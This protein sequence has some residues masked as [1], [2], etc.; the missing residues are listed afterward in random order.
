[1]RRN[2]TF[3][4]FLILF[5]M[6][7]I[8]VAQERNCSTMENLEYR[9]QQ[10]PGLVQRMAQLETYTQTKA[11]ELLQSKIVGDIITI[12]VV[13]HI[14]YR[15]SQENISDAQI[16]S[17]IDVLNEDF[18]RLNS[19]ADN[20]WSQAA[21]MQIEFCLA[22]VDPNGNATTGITRKSSTR[23][24]WGTN[25]A[26]KSVSQGGVAAW[27]TSEY[28]N[29]WV[30]N[31]GG[32]ILGYAQF[33]GGAASTDGVVMSPQYFGSSDKGTGFYLSAPFDKGR[34][35]THEVGH[36]LNLRHIWGDGGCG[37][38]D[39][40]SDT[41]TSD[42]S[43]GGC[44]IGH[45]SCGTVDM[46]QNYMDYSDDACMNLFTNGQ[47]A[48][49]RATLLPGGIRASLG[50]SDK[51]GGSTPTPTCNDGIQN[52]DETGVD[53]GGSCAPCTSGPQY[54][55][56]N[57]NSVA[58]EYISRV[59]LGSINNASGAAGSGYADF[60][61]QSTDLTKGASATITI[62]P[63]W[64]GT[65]YNEGYA[66]FIDYNQD[67]DFTDSGETV[68][69]RAASQASP[70]SGSFTVPSSAL[71][72]ATRM[73]VSM[74]YN[75][76]PTSCESFQYG[77]V[78]D[79]TV[80]IT[81][82]GGNPGG[83]N[84]CTGGVS[85]FP[86]TQSFEGSSFPG[87]SNASGNDINWATDSG[88]TPSSGTGPSTGADG[89]VYV[90]VETSG[91]GTGF[92]TKTAV[93]NAPCFDLSSA[94]SATFSFQY[95]MLGNAVGS[96]TVQA[97]DDNG[98][99]WTSIFSRSGSQGSSW[100]TAN[101]NIASYT[102]GSVQF[103]FNVVTGTSWQGDIA[104]DN[105]RVTTGNT[106]L[107]DDAAIREGGLDFKLYPNPATTQLNVSGAANNASY[108]I[109]NMVG[110]QVAKGRLTNNP[111]DVSSLSKGVYF[112]TVDTVDDSAVKRFIKE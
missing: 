95:H 112:L 41:P 35:T 77:E 105:V 97:S 48:R 61:S 33:P 23:T 102:G 11:Q 29:M 54:C 86:Y 101:L 19:D 8:S 100:R 56:S 74:K 84:G 13:V 32:G 96:L 16:Q 17:Q 98:A 1:M 34:T 14:V 52:G 44:N 110:Q 78:E 22:T 63:T 9:M 75:G 88:G 55:A 79:Y 42:A 111:I 68:Y 5:F 15:T 18:R 66:V 50:A 51:C 89:A 47:K 10:D 36:F 20:T 65:L 93:L 82:G 38:D 90:Y 6:L 107:E 99:T 30:A 108:T 31:I 103:R 4:C 3:G 87:W 83:G 57:G 76:I 73:R 43:N 94:S 53:C 21:D 40:V 24:S 72:G 70:V 91:N 7:G 39:F 59:Q 81:T 27:N 37:V 67:G 109:T 12:P 49:M 85:S 60:T 71:S 2:Y 106:R 62:T 58:D 28:L 69:T 80:N 25:D 45:V 104:I 46:V 26:V 92:P 64:T